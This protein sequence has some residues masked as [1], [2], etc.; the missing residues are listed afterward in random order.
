MKKFIWLCLVLSVSVCLSITYAQTIV[1]NEIL[2]SNNNVNTDPDFNEYGD[3]V[4]LYNSTNADI[5]IKGYYI[6]DDKTNPKKYKF[7]TDIII[8]AKGYRLIWTDDHNTGIHT[9][10]KLSASGEFLGLYNPNSILV[11]SLTFPIQQPN[12]SYGAYPNGTDNFLYFSP[13]TPE[14]ENTELSIFNRVPEPIFSLD[15]GFYNGTQTISI[16]CDEPGSKIYYTND[17]HT[18][19][20]NDNLYQHPININS[21][22]VIKAIAVKEGYKNSKIVT[23]TYFIDEQIDLPVFSISTDPEN[24]FSDTSG[25]YVKGTNGI[26]GNCSTEPRNW[27]QDWERP[28]SIEFFEKDKNKAFC[29]DAGVKIYGGCTRLYAQKSLAFYFRDSYGFKKLNYRLF[30]ELPITEYNNFI[31][32]S[33]GQDWWRT[34]FRDAFVQTII[35][36][37]MD[38]DNQAYRPSVLFI[39]GDYWGIH[40][41]REKLNEHYIEEH[42]QIKEDNI[43]LIEYSKGITAN[44]GD[45]IAYDAMMNYFQNNSLADSS[46]YEYIKSI[47]DINSFIDYYICQIYG[48]NADWPGSNTKLWHAKDNTVKWRFMVYD[49]DFTFGGN[50]N[51]QYNSNTL[52]L[53]TA[54][55]SNNYPNPAWSTL[56]IRK[57]L[58]N[59]NFKNEFIQRFASHINNTYEPN[60]VIGIIDSMKAVIGSEIPRHKI[61]WTQSVSYTT[62]W[63]NNVQIM[64]DFAIK[65]PDFIR[66]FIKNYFNLGGTYELTIN[67]NSNMGYI[68]INGVRLRQNNQVLFNDIPVKITAEAKPGYKFV[69][70][71]GV[72]SSTN[73]EITLTLNYDNYLFA[74]FEKINSPNNNL[75]INEICNKPYDLFDTGDWVEIFNPTENNINLR[76]YV[77]KDLGDN[78]FEIGKD[79]IIDSKGY[80]VIAQDTTKLKS[81]FPNLKNYIGNF[82]F[83]LSSEEDK[84]TL[85]DNANNIVNQIHYNANWGL[86][87]SYFIGHTLSLINPTLDNSQPESWTLSKNYGTPGFINDIYTLTENEKATLP[88]EFILYQNYPNPFNPVTTINLNIPHTANIELNVYNLLGQK[89]ETLYSGLINTGNYSFTFYS[90]NLTSGIYFYSLIIKNYNRTI[91]KKMLLLK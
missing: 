14:A 62:G 61:R 66:E 57:L 56:M 58:E 27:N 40:N 90:T 38:V 64:R 28:I 25:I 6:T 88:N 82:N 43:D 72:N 3:W 50:A 68:K 51:G 45:R 37:N 22:I 11:D 2:A 80:Y 18:P 24:F 70:W 39:N 1:I 65:R 47:L 91:T 76:G 69:K 79:I 87:N 8:P 54:A 81:L 10:F 42:Y 4:E 16:T 60:Y 83:G 20:K 26:I 46:K 86:N 31:L 52:A 59:T 29:V 78:I 73:K 7:T 48:A 5:N 36:K 35:R 13:P 15:A 63:D 41:I 49:T 30:P 12:I 21:T 9:N 55:N 19:T 67:T 32:R 53:A 17:G 84:I 89:I 85:L 44:V 34:M 75:I 33:S 71:E 74:I 77:I 23:K